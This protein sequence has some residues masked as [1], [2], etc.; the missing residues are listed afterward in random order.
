MKENSRLYGILFNFHAGR[1][2]FNHEGKYEL[3]NSNNNIESENKI[4]NKSLSQA[5]FPDPPN[6]A[7]FLE[8]Y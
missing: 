5:L 6:M 8:I 7:V 1:K 3:F 2:E 4:M